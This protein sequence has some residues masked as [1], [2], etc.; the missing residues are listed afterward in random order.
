M[1]L[2]GRTAVVYGGGGRIGSTVAAAFAREGAK[3]HVTGRT[4]ATVDAVAEAIRA[5]GGRADAAVVDAL[6]PL[7]VDD[8][9][10]TVVERDGNIDISMNVIAHGDVQGTPFVDMSLADYEAPVVTALRSTFLTWRAAGR[11]MRNQGSGVILAFGGEGAPMPDW[12]LGGLQTAFS[13][14]ES[15]RRQLAAELGRFG[16]RVVTLQTAGI[17]EVIPDDFEPRDEILELSLGRSLLHRSA[18][19]EDVGHAAVFAASDWGRTLTACQLNITCG[20]EVS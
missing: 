3:V 1:L 5:A 12:N 18:T 11:H 8:H 20:T 13:A 16:V 7:A 19:L 15:M 9:A 4:L 10:D 14:I 2:E 17:L 6:D